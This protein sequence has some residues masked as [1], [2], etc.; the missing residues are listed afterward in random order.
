M[1]SMRFRQ[2]ERVKFQITAR[3]LIY[4]NNKPF[5]VYSLASLDGRFHFNSIPEPAKKYMG[6]WVKD[7]VVGKY[8]NYSDFDG[9]LLTS[10]VDVIATY[11]VFGKRLISALIDNIEIFNKDVCKI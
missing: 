7:G 5:M 4:D 11:S 8:A 9:H 10:Y 1:F 2:S 3:K 6:V